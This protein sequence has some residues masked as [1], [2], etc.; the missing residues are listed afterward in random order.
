[1]S[2]PQDDIRECKVTLQAVNKIACTPPHKRG[3]RSRGL[4]VPGHA[5][6]S[7]YAGMVRVFSTAQHSKV[8]YF[9]LMN[10]GVSDHSI[11]LSPALFLSAVCHTYQLKWIII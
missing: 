1:M 6:Q 2:L 4:V 3:F 7:S 11:G 9:T 5:M 8:K 10:S